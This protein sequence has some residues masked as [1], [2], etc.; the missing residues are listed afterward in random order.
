MTPISSVGPLP[1]FLHVL[2][3]DVAHLAWCIYT[4]TTHAQSFFCAKCCWE[5]EELKLF[6]FPQL[7]SKPSS[8]SLRVGNWSERKSHR[9]PRL[10]KRHSH[11]DMLLLAQLG[12]PSSP[13]SLNEDSLSTASELLST[14]RARR[15]P[16]VLA[17]WS[18][19][20]KWC[21]GCKASNTS[22]MLGD[23]SPACKNLPFSIQ[24]VAL[25][26]SSFSW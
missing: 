10:P 20:N 15:I 12:I 6:L 14:R 13:T 26:E 5:G 7:P 2:C 19:P 21:S 11:D 16:K 8:Q 25:T 17:G 1:L 4:A 3:R 9:L 24:H 22:L 23:R 18:C